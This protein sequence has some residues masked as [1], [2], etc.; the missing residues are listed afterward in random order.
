MIQHWSNN[1]L[2]YSVLQ[3]LGARQKL[4]L[5]PQFAAFTLFLFP[6]V[7]QF[8]ISLRLNRLFSENLS[9]PESRDTEQLRKEVSDNVSVLLFVGGHTYKSMKNDCVTKFCNFYSIQ[10]NELYK[11]IP[12]AQK[13]QRTSF[14]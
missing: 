9:R 8:P 11:Q 3:K 2:I 6:S 10:L 7:V 12:G 1:D 13:V 5:R 14:R 4:K